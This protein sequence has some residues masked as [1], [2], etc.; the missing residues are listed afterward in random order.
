[1]AECLPIL[2]IPEQRPIPSMRNDVVNIRG[3]CNPAFLHA[4]Y[5]ERVVA[6]ECESRLAPAV[7]VQSSRRGRSGV[8]LTVTG[9]DSVR[10]AREE[11]EHLNSQWHDLPIPAAVFPRPTDLVG[12]ERN[13][14]DENE[15]H[16]CLYGVEPRCPGRFYRRS[17]TETR[18]VA[19]V[20][21]V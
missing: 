4:R 10:A 18:N 8:L 6:E 1:V 19:P 21:G 12:E 20:V 9:G 2:F 13:D 5:T 15:G 17:L 14:D 16:G 3:W 7:I 11:T